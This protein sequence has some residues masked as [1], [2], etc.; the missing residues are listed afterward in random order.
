MSELTQKKCI[1]CEGGLPGLGARQI[2]KLNLITA[3]IRPPGGTGGATLR[4]S[5]SKSVFHRTLVPL[6]WGLENCD[7][8]TDGSERRG[9][10]R[11]T[12]LESSAGD[13]HSKRSHGSNSLGESSRSRVPRMDSAK[14]ISEKY[15]LL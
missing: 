2:G 8:A 10:T 11:N 14:A 3:G 13:P 7:Q 9:N 15:V 4:P 1:P 5:E 6:L 12:I